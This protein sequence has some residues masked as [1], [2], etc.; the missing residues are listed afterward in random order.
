MKSGA[1]I[2]RGLD[3]DMLFTGELSHHDALAAVEKGQVVLTSTCHVHLV[4]FLG[5][6]PHCCR[7]S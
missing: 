7:Q 1:S 6:P 5:H 4:P 2:F 3:V